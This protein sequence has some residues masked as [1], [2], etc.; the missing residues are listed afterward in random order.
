VDEAGGRRIPV[1]GDDEVAEG[2]CRLEQPELPGAR[3]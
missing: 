1:D 2:T 3:P